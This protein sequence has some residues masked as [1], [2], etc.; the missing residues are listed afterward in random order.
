MDTA[1]PATSVAVVGGDIAVERRDDPGPGERPAHTTRLLALCE[2]AL[3]GAGAGWDDVE[4]LAA[5]TGPGSFTG[6]RIGLATAHGLALSRSLPLVGVSSLRALAATARSAAPGGRTAA[7]IDARRGEA[8]A[9][10]F[11][12]EAEVMEP[13]AAAPERLGDALAALPGP[14]MAVGDGALRFRSAIEAAGLEVPDADSPL[15][16]VHATSVARLAP[17][18]RSRDGASVLPDYIRRPDAEAAAA[19]RQRE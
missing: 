12:G 11:D 8:F 15:H 19:R 17:G 7:V 2:E 3:A 4:L 14:R 6:L 13:V 18:I 1:T 5:G 16:R 10:A 9:A